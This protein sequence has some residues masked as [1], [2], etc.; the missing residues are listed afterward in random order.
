MLVRKNTKL[1]FLL[2]IFIMP[3][4]MS[5]LLFYFHDRFHFK[6]LNRGH[7]VNPPIPVSYLYPTDKKIWLIIQVDSSEKLNYQLNQLRKALGQDQKRV[8]VIRINEEANEFTQLKLS[9]GNHFEVK[10]KIYLV[11]PL[12][13][14]FMYYQSST[15]PMDILK[16]LKKVLKVSQIG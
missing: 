9:F 2:L 1:Y 4:L 16:D 6:T 5:S 3:V 14:L 12:G 10:N 15:N 8:A 11:D 7:L 13:N